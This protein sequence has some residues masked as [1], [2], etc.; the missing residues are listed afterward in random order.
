LLISKDDLTKDSFKVQ[1]KEERIAVENFDRVIE[2]IRVHKA[3]ACYRG[4]R[5]KTY[6][7]GFFMILGEYTNSD[8]YS[9]TSVGKMYE[10][11]EEEVEELKSIWAQLKNT[12]KLGVLSSKRLSYVFE[13]RNIEDKLIDCFVGLESLYL[14]ERNPELTFRLSIRVAKMI[15]EDSVSQKKLFEFIKDM[16]A[17]RSKVAHGSNV[18]VSPEEISQLENILRSSIKRY[19]FDKGQFSEK[20]LNDLLFI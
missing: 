6:Y 20:R 19:L 7:S 2:A 3:S 10:I 14:P 8:F 5:I 13:R 17:K 11:N 9:R 12:S 4:Y 1:I 18:D 16:Y 15:N